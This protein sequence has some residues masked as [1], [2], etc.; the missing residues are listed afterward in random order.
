MEGSTGEDLTPLDYPSLTRD[1]P[2]VHQESDGKRITLP[3]WGLRYEVELR[4]DLNP[5]FIFI[6]DYFIGLGF[7]F[8]W[9][10][11]LYFLVKYEFVI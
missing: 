6:K 1:Y 3:V 8:L 10:K 2:F 9:L 7:R 11:S 4:L 5:S